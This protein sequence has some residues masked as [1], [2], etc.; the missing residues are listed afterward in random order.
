MRILILATG[1]T[2]TVGDSY[3]RRQ[4]EQGQAVLAPPA[5]KPEPKA[6]KAKKE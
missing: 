6:A 4:I 3:G 5:K 1:E 2:V